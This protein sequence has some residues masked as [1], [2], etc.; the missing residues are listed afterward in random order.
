ML[1]RISLQTFEFFDFFK[2]NNFSI[3]TL[4]NATKHKVLKAKMFLQVFFYLFEHLSDYVNI[5]NTRRPTH[6][7][8]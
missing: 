4:K 1:E 2:M 7:S 3:Y 8:I 6:Q 5:V